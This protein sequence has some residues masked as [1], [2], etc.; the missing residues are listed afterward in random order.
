VTVVR[1]DALQLPFADAVFDHVISLHVLDHTPDNRLVCREV[2]RVLRPGGTFLALM[3]AL[4]GCTLFDQGIAA[5]Y[6]TVHL[7]YPEREMR[8]WF[9]GTRL[10]LVTLVRAPGFTAN[11]AEALSMMWVERALTLSNRLL[12]S[13][14]RTSHWLWRI[15]VRSMDLVAGPVYFL[16]C[17]KPPWGR[18]ADTGQSYGVDWV[19]IARRSDHHQDV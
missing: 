6:A 3:P 7:H 1:A 15:L 18:P 10:E 14:R 8:N 11:L 9:V 4:L 2:E 5:Q 17:S 12:G 13:Q 19:I 16:F